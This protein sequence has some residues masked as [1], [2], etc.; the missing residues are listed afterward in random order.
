MNSKE[1]FY[2]VAEMREAQKRYFKMHTSMDLKQA[3]KLEKDVDEEIS[4][5]QDLM[6][7]KQPTES[8]LFPDM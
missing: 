1:F 8:D 3:K 7:P 2:K 6:K 5:V 4:R